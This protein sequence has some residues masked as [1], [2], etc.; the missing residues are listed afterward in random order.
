MEAQN[1]DFTQIN[2]Q[3]AKYVV[4]SVIGMLVQSLYSTLF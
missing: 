3:F 1:V 4:P 2:K